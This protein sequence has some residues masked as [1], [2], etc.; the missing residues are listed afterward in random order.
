MEFYCQ[1][2]IG[3]DHDLIS[4]KHIYEDTLNATSNYY[5]VQLWISKTLFY[6]FQTS[7]IGFVILINSSLSIRA[8]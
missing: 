4:I 3:I 5:L 1:N 6:L 7:K 2:D 8:L